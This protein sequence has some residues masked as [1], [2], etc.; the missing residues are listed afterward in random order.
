MNLGSKYTRSRRVHETPHSW[1]PVICDIPP[2]LAPK[3]QILRLFTTALGFNIMRAGMPTHTHPCTQ[4]KL[5][6]FFHSFFLVPWHKA[7]FTWHKWRSTSLDH[8]TLHF[9]RMKAARQTRRSLLGTNTTCWLRLSGIAK[10][11]SWVLATSLGLGWSQLLSRTEIL[12]GLCKLIS[13][14]RVTP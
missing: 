12:T 1:M 4:N 8:P 2:V 11:S 5:N 3:R 6:S 14:S 9:C 13:A 7:V 10:L